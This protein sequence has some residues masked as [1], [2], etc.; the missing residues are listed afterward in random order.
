M[1]AT[2]RGKERRKNDFYETPAFTVRRY[3]D[4]RSL[5]FPGPRWIEPSAG[6]GAIIR[7]VNAWCEAQAV[8]HPTW[9]AIELDPKFMDLIDTPRKLCVDFLSPEVTTANKFDLCIGNPPYKLAR[10]FIEKGLEIAHKVSYLLRLNFLESGKR[11]KFFQSH[12]C[13]VFVLPNRP[14]F[15]QDGH[16]DATA[17]GWFEFGQGASGKLSILNTTPKAERLADRV[18]AA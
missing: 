8:D 14:S 7:A 16:T 15:Y 2:G 18:Q 4:A 17:Y 11:F 13:D 10:E 3:M 9:S 12:P 5:L 6:R 1:S